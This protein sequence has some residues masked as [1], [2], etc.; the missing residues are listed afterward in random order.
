MKK[1]NEPDHGS[2]YN[3]VL[4]LFSVGLMFVI[5]VSAAFAG[6][7][8]QLFTVEEVYAKAYLVFVILAFGFYF[9]MVKDNVVIGLVVSKKAVLSGA[10]SVFI[11]ILSL[12]LYRWFVPLWGIDGVAIV[13]AFVQII[14]F[15]VIYIAAQKVHPIP[16]NIKRVLLILF[17]GMGLF[18]P[19]YFTADLSFV[20]KY[21]VKCIVII[22]YPILIIRFGILPLHEIKAFRR[23]LS[24]GK[25]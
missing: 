10:I 9:E 23:S 24:K 20:L 8:I 22:L 1:V 14:Y 15:V 16:Y 3:T 5:L 21:G 18:L 2:F 11:A 17:I 25:M 13:F 6:E 4:Q 19:V 12:V 7:I